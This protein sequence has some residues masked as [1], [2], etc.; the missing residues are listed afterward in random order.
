MRE[1]VTAL[2][3]LHKPR[4]A[5]CHGNHNPSTQNMSKLYSNHIP[6]SKVPI[7]SQIQRITSPSPEE[8][9]TMHRTLINYCLYD[10]YHLN[11]H[12]QNMLE[13]VMD[14]HGNNVASL[15]TN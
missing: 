3:P 2:Q 9:F 13:T 6:R 11:K 12:I 1:D 8:Q 4:C 15:I 14:T 5:K 10:L 7:H